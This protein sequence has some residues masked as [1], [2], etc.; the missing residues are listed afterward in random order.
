[1]TM[2]TG[3]RSKSFVSKLLDKLSPFQQKGPNE[4][5]SEVQQDETLV[6]NSILNAS[7]DSEIFFA[8][9]NHNR[10]TPVPNET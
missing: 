6:D 8:Q 3:T 2:A 9:I 10:S 4:S 5:E 7:T 1:M